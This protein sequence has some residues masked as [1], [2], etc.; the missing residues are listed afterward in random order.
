VPKTGRTKKYKIRISNYN[1][2][3]KDNSFVLY[4]A[5]VNDLSAAEN[6]IRALFSKKVYRSRKEYYTVSLRDA[7][8]TIKKCIKL[9]GSKLLSENKFYEKYRTTQWF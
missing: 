5:K 7:M 3:T 4:R 2:A 1:S 6:C 8:K 9:S